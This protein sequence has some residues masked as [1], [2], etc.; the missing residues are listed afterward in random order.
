MKFYVASSFKNIDNVRYISEQLKAEGHIH[1]YDWT[2]HNRASSFEELKEIGLKE[3][4][5][6]MESDVVIVLLPA[7]KGSHIELGIALGMN[8][9]IILHSPGEEV[10]DISETSTFYHLEEVKKFL[11][12]KEGLVDFIVEKETSKK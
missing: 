11:G 10:N 3:K 8:K 7:G 2:K 5:A 4:E 1:T 12:D 9:E 6:V